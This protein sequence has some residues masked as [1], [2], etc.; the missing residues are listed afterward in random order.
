MEPIGCIEARK[1]VAIR[2]L[3]CPR[4]R[5]AVEVYVRDGQLTEDCAC[6]VCGRV[7]PAGTPV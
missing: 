3:P 5:A 1:A 4:C 7:I 6:S 2:E